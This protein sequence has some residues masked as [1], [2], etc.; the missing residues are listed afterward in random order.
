MSIAVS[1][2]I[3][4]GVR[5]SGVETVGEVVLVGL[6]V[7]WIMVAVA[8]CGGSVLGARTVGVFMTGDRLGTG[9][10]LLLV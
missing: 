6:G 2:E 7:T 9:D 10:I 4:E 5:T 8:I 1:P 3:V